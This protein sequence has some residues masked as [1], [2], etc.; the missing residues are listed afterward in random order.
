MI[1]LIELPQL[2]AVSMALTAFGT[3]W[4]K[5][6][7]DSLHGKPSKIEHFSVQ[8]SSCSSYC[9]AG[10][11]TYSRR[12]FKY[13]GQEMSWVSAETHCLSLGANLVSIHNDNEYQLVK[14][15]IRVNDH[16]EN[17]TW[18]GLSDCQQ[19]KTWIWSDGTKLNYTK[20]NSDEPN[21]TEKECCVHMNWRDEKNWNDIPCTLKYP[22]VCV[23][24][25]A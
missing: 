11:V 25:L 20:W 12:C 24:K 22:F 16:M 15:L 2:F 14:A 4:D 9:P 7:K 3:D 6:V 19:E 8:Y 5:V 18:I 1:R 17:P 21:F 23:K 13:V 10:W